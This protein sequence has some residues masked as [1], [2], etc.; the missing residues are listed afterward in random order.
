LFE[1]KN[2][3]NQEKNEFLQI[4]LQK[5]KILSNMEINDK[6]SFKN[7]IFDYK[8]FEEYLPNIFR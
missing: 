7:L 4:I 5:L 6:K 1:S 8:I 3:S 2:I